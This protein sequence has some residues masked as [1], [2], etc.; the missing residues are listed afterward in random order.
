MPTPR[1]SD[2][3]RNRAA[4]L[5]VAGEALTSGTEPPPLPEIARRAGVGQATVYRHFSDRRTLAVEV[6]RDQLAAL[7]AL[8]AADG[9]P[10]AF[11]SVLHVVLSA[12]AAGRPLVAL[13]RE[14]PE[15][16]QRAH[17]E[18]LVGR[19]AEPLRRA[20]AAGAARDD[21]EAGDL[22]LLLAMVEAAVETAGGDP[23]AVARTITTLVAGV[24]PAFD[25]SRAAAAARCRSSGGEPWRS[26]VSPRW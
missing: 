22:V 23:A 6:M 13:L 26:K 11:A 5:R 19:L 24:C 17:A 1:R 8:I 4:I 3:R 20:Q 18:R 12:Q 16:D 14:L 2:A 7:D 9:D 15:A 25:V 10:A 21:V